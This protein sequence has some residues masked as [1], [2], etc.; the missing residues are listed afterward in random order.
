MIWKKNR[1]ILPKCFSWQKGDLIAVYWIYKIFTGVKCDN[2]NYK[3]SSYFYKDIGCVKNDKYANAYDCPE[4]PSKNGSCRYENHYIQTGEKIPQELLKGTCIPQCKCNDEWVFPFHFCSRFEWIFFGN[5]RF[6]CFEIYWS[7]NKN[8]SI[9]ASYVYFCS[10]WFLRIDFCFSKKISTWNPK[11]ATLSH[12]FIYFVLSNHLIFGKRQ[13][14][15]G[16]EIMSPISC[17]QV[18]FSKFE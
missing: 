17:R 14:I 18:F 1:K 5:E 12:I 6:R 8:F 13:W 16:V 11:K 10:E 2:F 7:M 3:L 9:I 4:F 15:F